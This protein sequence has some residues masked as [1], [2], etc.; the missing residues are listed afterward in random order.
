MEVFSNQSRF[1]PIMS[2]DISLI[3]PVS[4][5][6]LL[7]DVPHT[8]KGG[9]YA[10]G[11]TREASLNVTYNY[12]PHFYRVVGEKGIRT[13][14]GMTGAESVPL[15]ER[16]AEMLADDVDENYWKSTEG[17]AKRALL[18]LANLARLCPDGVW[19]GD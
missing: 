7:L 13:L 2:Y 5:E 9:T 16:A 17:N 14:Y 11:G 6:T 19:Y 10:I 8:M 4:K 12:A 15:L 3:D 18:D 1:D